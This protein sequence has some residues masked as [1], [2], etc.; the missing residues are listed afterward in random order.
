MNLMEKKG[1]KNNEEW[2]RFAE[3]LE[4]MRP[5]DGE[6][7]DVIGWLAAIGIKIN[8]VTSKNNETEQLLV[9]ANDSKQILQQLVSFEKGRNGSLMEKLPEEQQNKKLLMEKLPAEWQNKKFRMEQLPKEWKDK[10]QT[11]VSQSIKIDQPQPETVLIDVDGTKQAGNVLQDSLHIRQK[12]QSQ[13][14][15]EQ[16]KPLD[17]AFF[18]FSVAPTTGHPEAQALSVEA[19]KF[20]HEF[21]ELLKSKIQMQKFDG[22]IQAKFALNPQH[23]GHVDITVKIHEGQVVAQFFADTAMGKE[24]I[25]SQIEILKHALQEQGMQV[26][27]V[28]V[29]NQTQGAWN[30]HSQHGGANSSHQRQKQ[31]RSYFTGQNVEEVFQSNLSIDTSIQGINY[32]A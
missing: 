19:R 28:D 1:T 6:L 17:H 27:R 10:I 4:P 30:Q 9:N 23:L 3:F 14:G 32:R 22:N 21:S 13:N 20:P 29:Y 12:K 31:K 26:S 11:I 25:E 24:L 7:Q 8:L 15:V 2:S 16:I 18:S 5:N